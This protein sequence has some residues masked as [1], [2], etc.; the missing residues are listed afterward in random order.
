MYHLVY[1][2][3]QI[4]YFFGM[5]IIYIHASTLLNCVENFYESIWIMR[6]FVL[7]WF[8]TII[9]NRLYM[10]KRK[11]YARNENFLQAIR[12]FFIFV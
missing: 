2:F 11:Q 3:D 8:Y 1:S 9:Q 7:K 12:T 10:F 4:N 5:A 6:L